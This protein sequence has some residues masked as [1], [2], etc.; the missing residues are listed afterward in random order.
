MPEG[1]TKCLKLVSTLSSTVSNLALNVRKSLINHVKFLPA[2]FA[3]LNSRKK[4]HFSFYTYPRST[5]LFPTVI[6]SQST[7]LSAI[8]ARRKIFK[9][10]RGM[11][12]TFLSNPFFFSSFFVT[13]SNIKDCPKVLLNVSNLYRPLLGVLL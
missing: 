10:N 4:K 6:I 8:A 3:S 9:S 12:I 2:T 7:A 5:H 13:T 11:R 1:V